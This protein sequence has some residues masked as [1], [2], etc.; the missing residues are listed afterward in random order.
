V[1]DKVVTHLPKSKRMRDLVARV[2]RDKGRVDFV[3]RYSDLYGAYTEAE[4]IYTDD[5]T[6]EL[7]GSLTRPTGSGSRS[8]RRRSTGGTT[9]RT[10]TARR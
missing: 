9:S 2:D 5:R 1:A 8:T 6:V 4:V 10:C 7:W 3:R